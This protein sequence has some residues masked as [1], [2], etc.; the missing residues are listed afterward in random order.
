MES[1]K[2]ERAA[3]R[4]GPASLGEDPEV[5]SGEWAFK[6]HIRCPPAGIG[7]RQDQPAWVAGEPAEPTEG[8]WEPWAPLVGG[9]GKLV[10]SPMGQRT[11]WGLIQRLPSVLWSITPG[12]V[13]VWAMNTAVLLPSPHS[14][15]LEQGRPRPG[16]ELG[17]GTE[18]QRGP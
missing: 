9:M 18:R 1:G 7:H 2:K 17:R 15:A 13:P 4:S 5:C 6:P 10:C 16:R 3:V 12:H 11:D 14:P 8:V